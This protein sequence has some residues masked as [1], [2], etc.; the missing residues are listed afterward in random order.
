MT[1]P[2]DLEDPRVTL[3]A[4]LSA[5]W[6]PANV[7]SVGT[8]AFRTEWRGTMDDTPVVT[9]TNRDDVDIAARGYSSIRGDGS[10]VASRK[11]GSVFV[12]CWSGVFATGTRAANPN[13][14]TQAK[15]MWAEVE[16]IVIAHATGSGDLE[17]LRTD[18]P[19]SQDE[20]TDAEDLHRTFGR[21]E[22]EY[23]LTPA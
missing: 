11:R 1:L 15:E 16:R 8:P 22:Y 14:K 13:P 3:L 20:G 17:F 4:L 7:P 19:S 23:Q 9:I 21:I 12:N 10:G 6:L 5:E 2:K 18:G